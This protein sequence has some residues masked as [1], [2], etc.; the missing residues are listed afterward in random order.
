MFPSVVLMLKLGLMFKVF[1]EYNRWI[2][3]AN[4]SIV[5]YDI[6]LTL[7]VIFTCKTLLIYFILKNYI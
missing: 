1:R 3:A 7:F 2:R 6:V 5:I 4:F